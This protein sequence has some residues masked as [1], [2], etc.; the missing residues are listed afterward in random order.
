[1]LIPMALLEGARGLH[2]SHVVPVSLTLSALLA[3]L[4]YREVRRTFYE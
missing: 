2:P 1:M 3:V 4:L